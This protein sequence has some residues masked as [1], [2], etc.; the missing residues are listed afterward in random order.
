M[1]RSASTY[2]CGTIDLA[3]LSGWSDD[4]DSTVAPRDVVQ[5]PARKTAKVEVAER[6]P[7]ITNETE[8]CLLNM[9]LEAMLQELKNDIGDLL[10]RERF[11]IPWPQL[12]RGVINVNHCRVKFPI[13]EGNI[14]RQAAQDACK[15]LNEAMCE[16]KV[17]IATS[18][19]QRWGFYE[20]PDA[21]WQPSHLFV[22]TA[23]KKRSEATYL[24]SGIIAILE[25]LYADKDLSIN[26]RNKDFGGGGAR[27]QATADAVH[28]VYLAVKPVQPLARTD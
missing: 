21:N 3:I 17:G 26:Q 5:P 8:Y 15:I 22:L 2:V 25:V 7:P 19:S 14:L 18:V 6:K 20:D 11:R 9:T 28:F 27:W 16:Y 23:V 1:R 12:E 13:K 4:E 10:V 24:E